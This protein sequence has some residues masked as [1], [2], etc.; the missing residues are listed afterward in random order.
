MC[1]YRSGPANEA[2]VAYAALAKKAKLSLTE[3]SLLWCRGRKLPTTVLVGT[4]TDIGPL[5]GSNVVFCR[6]IFFPRAHVHEAVGRK[7][8]DISIKSAAQQGVDVGNR[9]GAYAKSVANIRI[10]PGRSRL[11]WRGRDWRKNSIDTICQEE[12]SE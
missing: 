3:L 10:G 4:A 2:T 12:R 6:F 9:S 5:F 7:H 11:V 1:R 8:K